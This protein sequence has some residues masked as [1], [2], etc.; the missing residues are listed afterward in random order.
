MGS[1]TSGQGVSAR[2]LLNTE[3]GVWGVENLDTPTAAASS[4]HGLLAV[5]SDDGVV[6]GV[7][8]D[9]CARSEALLMLYVK[10]A[11]VALALV[12]MTLIDLGALWVLLGPMPRILRRGRYLVSA[13]SLDIRALVYPPSLTALPPEPRRSLTWAGSHLDSTGVIIEHA[14]VDGTEG[15]TLADAAKRITKSSE[16]LYIRGGPWCLACR[17]P[18]VHA[19][20]S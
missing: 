12:L 3:G 5:V 14:Q 11:L 9:G 15:L 10:L 20:A 4:A 16:C 2:R 19:S 8:R 6:A 18:S 13:L 17:V 7:F 1:L